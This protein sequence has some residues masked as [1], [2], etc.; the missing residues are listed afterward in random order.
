D[1][2]F[3]GGGGNDVMT[4][5]WS[6]PLQGSGS[7]RLRLDGGEGADLLYAAYN[8]NSAVTLPNLDLLAQGGRGQDILFLSLADPSGHA[9]YGP[10]GA[11]L[12]D[13]GADEDSCIFFG[14]GGYQPLSCESGS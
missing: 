11:A 1:V 14:A 3:Q 6:S 10:L 8:L 5:D 12:L 7:T 13:G 9:T 4:V 2:D